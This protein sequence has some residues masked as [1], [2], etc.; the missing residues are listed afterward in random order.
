MPGAHSIHVSRLFLTW[1][2]PELP[3]GLLPLTWN[4]IL[5]PHYQHRVLNFQVNYQTAETTINLSHLK[6]H[7]A[8]KCPHSV[9]RLLWDVG[10]LWSLSVFQ[11]THHWHKYPH[12]LL[13]MLLIYWDQRQAHRG[14]PALRFGTFYY[15]L[16]YSVHT[17]GFHISKE[18]NK[19]K[20]MKCIAGVSPRITTVWTELP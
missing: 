7:C 6:I 11:R 8:Q 4:I 17:I 20:R 3:I 9:T 10:T 5:S 15:N 14:Y 19:K 13:F 18:T 12:I 2:S 16:L 1:Y